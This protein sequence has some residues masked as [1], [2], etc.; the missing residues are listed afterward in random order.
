MSGISS[1]T[2]VTKNNYKK[3]NALY[4]Q[5]VRITKEIK[6][7]STKERKHALPCIEL[8]AQVKDRR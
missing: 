7:K 4:Y 1:D 3:K 2:K 6:K 8:K 5:Q